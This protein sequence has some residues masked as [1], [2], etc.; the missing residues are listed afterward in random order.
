MSTIYDYLASYSC[1]KNNMDCIYPVPLSNYGK[2]IVIIVN[3]ASE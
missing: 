3:V 2:K 1:P